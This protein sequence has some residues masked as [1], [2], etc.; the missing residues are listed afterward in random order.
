LRFHV[1]LLYHCLLV[2]VR[3]EDKRYHGS[4]VR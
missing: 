4:Y 1:V 3:S 2:D